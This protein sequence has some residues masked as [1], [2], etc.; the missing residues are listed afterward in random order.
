MNSTHKDFPLQS[1]KKYLKEIEAYLSYMP[2]TKHNPQGFNSYTKAK[3]L[4]QGITK[5][6]KAIKLLPRAKGDRAHYTA[7]LLPSGPPSMF[8]P[9]A[10]TNKVIIAKEKTRQAHHKDKRVS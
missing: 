5:G 6:T 1:S 4:E 2:L 3:L 9:S 7:P 8:F 10:P